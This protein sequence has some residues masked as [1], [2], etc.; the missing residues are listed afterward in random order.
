MPLHLLFEKAKLLKDIAKQIANIELSIATLLDKNSSIKQQCDNG[1]L[2]IQMRHIYA[3]S[4]FYW[5]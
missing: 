5:R 3:F 2:K 4:I 1:T